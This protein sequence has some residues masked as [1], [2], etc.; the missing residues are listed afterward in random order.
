VVFDPAD[1][2]HLHRRSFLA[3]WQELSSFEMAILARVGVPISLVEE[4]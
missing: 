3:R 4:L 1:T 2:T